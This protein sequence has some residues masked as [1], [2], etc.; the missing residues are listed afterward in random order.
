M[1]ALGRNM[2]NLFTCQLK[3][4]CSVRAVSQVLFR[5]Y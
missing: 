5:F 1:D 2:N 4:K 3:E